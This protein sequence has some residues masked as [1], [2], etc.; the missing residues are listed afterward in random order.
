M[1]PS[2]RATLHLLLA[3]MRTIHDDLT[4]LHAGI[5]LLH[6]EAAIAAL[7]VRLQR[8]SPTR[9][10]QQHSSASAQEMR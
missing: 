9:Q 6:I 3:Q 7:E 10:D 1:S 5:C 4:E 8:S 2:D